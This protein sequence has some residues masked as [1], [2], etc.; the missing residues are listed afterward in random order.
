[1]GWD[2]AYGKGKRVGCQGAGEDFEHVDCYGAIDHDAAKGRGAQEWEMNCLGRN[3]ISRNSQVPGVA[4][5]L[6]DKLAFHTIVAHEDD[7]YVKESNQERSNCSR[8]I[9]GSQADACRH[10]FRCDLNAVEFNACS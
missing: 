1:M 2:G 8:S 3:V 6:L 10:C 9:P 4:A 7:V 5:L